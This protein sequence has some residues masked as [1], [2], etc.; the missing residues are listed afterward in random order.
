MFHIVLFNVNCM[1][2]F[3]LSDIL[4]HFP[5]AL[6]VINLRLRLTLKG[7]CRMNAIA[8]VQSNKDLRN[9]PINQVGIKDLRFPVQIKSNDGLQHTIARLTMTVFLP[10]EQKGTHMSRFVALMEEHSSAI[11]YSQLQQM[12]KEM[13]HRLDSPAG[14]ISVAFPF[15]RKKTAPVSGIQ[16]LLD[17]DVVLTGEMKSNGDY[18]YTLKILVPVTSLCPCSKEISEYGAHNQRSHV[19]LTLSCN[20][21]IEIEEVI[22]WVEQQASC[23][24]YGLLKRPDEKFVTERAYENPKFV[25]DMVRDIAAIL[26]ADS[27]IDAFVL[28]SENFESIHNHS[29]YAVIT[30]PESV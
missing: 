22:D 17:Y 5:H 11:D 13:L 3:A 20:A 10:A 25:E 19:T 27:R 4:S 12:I 21:N 6:S 8:D 29:A 26:R 9:I 24:L 15:F 2:K 7:F 23:Q 1:P 18:A 30:Y 14:K 16:S 28:E